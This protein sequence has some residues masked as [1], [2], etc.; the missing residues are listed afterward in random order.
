MKTVIEKF[1]N[2]KTILVIH[3]IKNYINVEFH[4]MFVATKCDKK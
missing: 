3:K 4:T 1:R 2:L